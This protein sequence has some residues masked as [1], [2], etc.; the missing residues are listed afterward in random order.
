MMTVTV[1]RSF[2]IAACLLVLLMSSSCL[3]DLAPPAVECSTELAALNNNAEGVCN[4][5][6]PAP[7]QCLPTKSCEDCSAGETPPACPPYVVDRTK[8][9]GQCGRLEKAETELG[10]SCTPCPRRGCTELC[11]GRGAVFAFGLPALGK[12]TQGNP[13]QGNVN[14]VQGRATPPNGSRVALYARMRGS[15]FV[16][17]D[18]R[19]PGPDALKQIEVELDSEFRDVLLGDQN[20]ITPGGSLIFDVAAA[21][22]RADGMRPGAIVEIDCLV[23][24]WAGGAK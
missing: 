2:P 1:R 13:N 17:L 15:G 22:K 16:R 4:N 9:E 19:V 11:D 23:P 6:A 7:L 5:S 3:K 18:I 10:S 14:L 24:L 12:L 21:D 8:G 20:T